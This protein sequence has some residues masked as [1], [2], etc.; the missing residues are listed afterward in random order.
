MGREGARPSPLQLNR[1]RAENFRIKIVESQVVGLVPTNRQSSNVM[2]DDIANPISERQ[3]QRARV[4]TL[5]VHCVVATCFLLASAILPSR[6]LA[7]PRGEGGPP[8]PGGGGGPQLR[9][10][11]VVQSEGVLS[12]VRADVAPISASEVT[13]EVVGDQRVIRS[14]GIA[15]HQTGSFPNADN[16]NSIS[17]QKLYLYRCRRSRDNR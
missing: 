14:N 9:Y 15:L 12:L 6:T 11:E 16:P 5:S 2:N 10:H 17:P 4:L 1:W 13:I 3:A 7:Q 8:P